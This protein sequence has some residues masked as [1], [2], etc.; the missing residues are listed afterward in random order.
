MQRALARA[1]SSNQKYL[2]ANLQQS[3]RRALGQ[4]RVAS[5]VQLAMEASAQRRSHRGGGAAR[6]SRGSPAMDADECHRT[7]QF[8]GINADQGTS[9]A[10]SSYGTGKVPSSPSAATC[11]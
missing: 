3:T 11:T 2:R 1:L 4:T 5:V 8:V 6:H 10:D 9:A 7:D